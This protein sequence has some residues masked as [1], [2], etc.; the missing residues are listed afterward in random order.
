M[1]TKL[2]I[3]PRNPLL[4][5]GTKLL[6][7]LQKLSGLGLGHHMGNVIIEDVALAPA[8]IK[9]ARQDRDISAQSKLHSLER[10]VVVPGPH[11][12]VSRTGN[13]HFGRL[14]HSIIGCGKLPV[15]REARNARVLKVPCD[16]SAQAVKLSAACAV[17][18]HPAVVE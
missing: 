1:Q 2:G 6:S 10:G 16:N 5:E 14:E 18:L 12:T 11:H 17:C 13:R 4:N 15:R 9:I 8:R 7:L 3:L